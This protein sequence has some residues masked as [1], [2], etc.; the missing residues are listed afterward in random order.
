MIFIYNSYISNIFCHIYKEIIKTFCYH[1]LSTQDTGRRQ[2][3]K[4]QF[5]LFLH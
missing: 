3:R 2:T 5:A 4:K 1:V